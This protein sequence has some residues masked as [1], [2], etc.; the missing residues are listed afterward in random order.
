MSEDLALSSDAWRRIRATAVE[1]LRRRGQAEAAKALQALPFE[2]HNGTNAF[3]DEFYVLQ[4]TLSMD[5]YVDL[6]VGKAG[7]SDTSPY[8]EIQGVFSELG[9]YVRFIVAELEKSEA[10]A[11]SPPV[12]GVTSQ[13]VE[14]ALRDAEQL[15]GPS[16]ASSAVDRLHTAFHGY[17]LALCSHANLSI[18]DNPSTTKLFKLLRTQHPALLAALSSTSEATRIAN[19]LANIIDALN[20]IR[21]SSSLAHPN[22]RLLDEPEAMLVINT[23]RTLFHY[24]NGRASHTGVA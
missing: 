6:S 12:L 18:P 20:P 8:S 13:A 10:P 2:L 19:S 17:L 21:N 9:Y 22:E 16:G 1:L 7:D 15:V 14:R 5:R 4:A 11:V 23:V 24:L 3:N